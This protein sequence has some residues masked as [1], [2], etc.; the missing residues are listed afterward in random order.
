[1]SKVLIFEIMYSKMSLRS[2]VLFESQAFSQHHNPR[3]IQR[4][5]QLE[6]LAGRILVEMWTSTKTPPAAGQL[7]AF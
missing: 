7:L 1:M 4:R 3:V 5:S 6:V 2:Q